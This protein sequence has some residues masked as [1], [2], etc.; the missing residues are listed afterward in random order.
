MLTRQKTDREPIIKKIFKSVTLE[1]ARKQVDP[2]WRGVYRTG[3]VCLFVSGLIFLAVAV[4]SM[5]LGPA[6]SGGEEYL[7]SLAAHSLLARIN[8]GI[9]ALSDFLMLPVI[10]A[11]YLTLKQIDKNAMLVAAGLLI[12]YI[13]FDFAIT[14]LN[15][16][17]LV[18]LTQNYAA[19]ATAALRSAYVA[20][21]DYALATLPIATFCSFAVSSVGLIITGLV[22]LK[23][24]FSRPNALLGIV[25]GIEGTLGAFYV[26]FPPLAALLIPALITYGLWA[27]LGGVRLFRLGRRLAEEQGR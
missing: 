17:T 4:L 26:I 2:T 14:E 10:L 6:P 27:L 16:L 12:L 21:A 15:S 8:F 20:A 3:G 25:A 1:Q 11:F 19:A 22:M 24:V 23:G 18:A 7:K 5:L 9:Y 13:I